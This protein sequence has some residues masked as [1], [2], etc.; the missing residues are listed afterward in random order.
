[1]TEGTRKILYAFAEKSLAELGEVKK[2]LKFLTNRKFKFDLCVPSLKLAV[3]INGG[4]YVN[5]RHNRGG[6]GYEKDL[7]KL[8]LAQINGW[9]VLQFTYEQLAKGVLAE[10][11][12]QI[13]KNE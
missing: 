2:E 4:Q 13:I 3:E 11:L 6:V 10:T 12:K 5:G 7:E 8:N 1:M 9:I